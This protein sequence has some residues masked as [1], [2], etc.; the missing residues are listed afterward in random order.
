MA[1]ARNL[2]SAKRT[3]K[4]IALPFREAVAGVK[5]HSRY[6]NRW[7]PVDHRGLKADMPG[8]GGL[9]GTL[10]RTSV[11]HNRPAIVAAR[12]EYVDLVA[13]IGAI[14]VFP[15]FAGPRMHRQTQSAANAERIHL[16]PVPALSHERVI[17]RHRAVIA[18]P[19][20]FA[21]ERVRV[22]RIVASRGHEQRAVTAE[23]NARRAR[24]IRYEDVLDV[25]KRA[26]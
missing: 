9:P 16:W 19:Q 21:A 2:A 6:G 10:I 12:L 17:R 14:F 26:A 5:R 3:D 1:S 4:D 13:A 24:L 11:A 15:H 20:Y 25:G 18:K 7:H 23:S 22:L 8:R